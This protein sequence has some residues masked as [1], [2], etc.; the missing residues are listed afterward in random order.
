M[1]KKLK[2]EKK[3][4]K[5]ILPDVGSIFSS[6]KGRDEASL[7]KVRDI[8]IDLIDNFPNHPFKVTVNDEMLDSIKDNGVISPVLVRPKDNGRYELISGHRRKKASEILRIDK[9][10]CII[11][12]LTDDEATILMVDCNYQRERVLPSEKAF[13]YKLKL[14]AL[15]HQGKRNDLTSCQLGT[16]LS[17][18]KELGEEFGDS[19]RQVYRFIRLTYLLPKLLEYVDNS[20]IKDKEVLSIALSPAV[21]IS[22]LT[23]E[24]QQSLLDYIDFNQITP[25]HAQAIDLKEM[26]QNNKFT[27]EKMELLLDESKPNETPKIKVSMNR[28]SHVLPKHLKNDREREDYIIKAVEWYDKYQKRLKEKNSQER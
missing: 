13:A 27:V 22:F 7:E 8:S 28:L 15:N 5:I 26:S 11:R 10:P 16:K 20:I 3:E 6:Q 18:A 4:S 23:K 1:P 14:E 12:D 25:S 9:I 17:S 2:M 21:E 19:E 24:E